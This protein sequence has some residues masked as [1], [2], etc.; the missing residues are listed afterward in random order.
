MVK[1]RRMRWASHVALKKERILHI[2]YWWESQEGRVT[3]ETKT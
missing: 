2:D 3:V 1:S